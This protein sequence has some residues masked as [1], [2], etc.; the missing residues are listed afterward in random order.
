MVQ[1]HLLF[2]TVTCCVCLVHALL[3][4]PIQS[5]SSLYEVNIPYY[6]PEGVSYHQA[7]DRIILSSLSTGEIRAFPNTNELN[8]INKNGSSLL[9]PGSHNGIYTPIVGVKV[10]ENTLYGAVGSL[11]PLPGPFYGGLLILDLQN[12]SNVELV[13]FSSLYDGTLMTPNDVVYSSSANAIF[14]T[15]FYGYRIFRYDLSTLVNNCI[16]L[17]FSPPSLSSLLRL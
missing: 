1:Q 14:V 11:P 10:Y 9:Y 16:F 17:P 8:S 4:Q 3:F 5:A 13:D 2:F 15:D 12:P 6:V 7:T